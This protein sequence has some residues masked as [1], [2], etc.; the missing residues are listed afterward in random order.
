MEQ[1]IGAVISA[2]VI[3]AVVVVYLMVKDILNNGQ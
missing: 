1:V 2:L 3:G